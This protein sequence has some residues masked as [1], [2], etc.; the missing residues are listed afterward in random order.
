MIK[1]LF[2]LRHFETNNNINGNLNGQS[3]EEPICVGHYIEKRASFDTIY[4]STALR[5]KQ[6][7]EWV[8]GQNNIIFTEQLLERNLGLLEGH[9]R[10]EMQKQYPELFERDR[11]NVFSTPPE[12]ES[13]SEFY[14]RAS[15]FWVVSNNSNDENVMICSHNQMLKILYFVIFDK[16]VTIQAWEQLRFPHGEIIKIK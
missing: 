11:F 13:Y 6:T 16:A 4:C 8:E 2:F 5:C 9:P 14:G 10:T 1:H 3:L 12:G 15:R 7:V